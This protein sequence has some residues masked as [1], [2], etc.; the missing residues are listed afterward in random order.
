MWRA[1]E[2]DWMNEERRKNIKHVDG[3]HIYYLDD[4]SDSLVGMLNLEVDGD[5]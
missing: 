1:I 2:S 5:S 4:A 3:K